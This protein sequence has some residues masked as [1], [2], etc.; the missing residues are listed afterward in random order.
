M[1]DLPA[2]RRKLRLRGIQSRLIVYFV[3]S[4]ALVMAAVELVEYFGVPGTSFRGQL[5]QDEQEATATL[6][7]IAD[8]KEDRL[9][10]WLAERQRDLTLLT[11]DQAHVVAVRD[12]MQ[13]VDRLREQH[14][15][16]ETPWSEVRKLPSYRSLQARVHEIKCNYG[17]YEHILVVDA[18]SGDVVVADDDASLGANWRRSPCFSGALK[19]D[20]EFIGDVRSRAG[21]DDPLMCFSRLVR[22]PE[23]APLCVWIVEVNLDEMVRP[24]L[25]TGRGLGERGEALLVD[26][27]GRLLTS[28]KHRLADGRPARPLEY[29]IT[30]EPARRAAAGERGTVEARDYR[31]EWVLAAYRHISI[32]PEFGWGL[33][34][35]RD[36]S[37]LYAPQR[38]TVV[39]TSTICLAGILAVT[40]LVVLVARNVT[41][42][43]RA[44]HGAAQ[45]LAQDNLTARAPVE[46]NDE[47]GELADAFNRM[48]ARLAEQQ[49]ALRRQERL[50]AL[51]QLTATVSHELRNPLGTLRTALYI[52]AQRLRGQDT[53]LDT[54]LDRM[55]RSIVRC[56]AIVSE[57]LEYN[58]LRPLDVQPTELDAWLA[59]TL[60]ELPQ[61]PAVTLHRD[62]RAAATLAID[63]ERLR[64]CLV[65]LVS[66]AG[67][68]MPRGGELTVSAHRDDGHVLIDIADTGCGILPADLPKIF[69]P[70]F[71]TKS[72]GVGLGLCIVK[73]IV[74]QHG[75]RVSV[76]SQMGTGTTFHVEL[77]LS[78]PGEQHHE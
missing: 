49:A 65:N 22:T 27:D 14:V 70:L 58:R 9:Q 25:H 1:S 32:T 45:E 47:V 43:L 17:E 57:L 33:V 63:R 24:M 59:E 39:Q 55:E 26:Q 46:S 3:G 5:S 30:A 44:L 77:P 74:E 78:P 42:P 21:R 68:A 4:F 11:N 7:L 38:W 67:D 23:K 48:V 69:E 60:D 12:L 62:L 8:L 41:R 73:Q 20:R 10:W 31:G 35:K 61:R 36:L 2:T 54:V 37:E 18:Y 52:V 6:V 29:K 50:A 64:R 53:S 15:A 34:V 13:D 56:D 19:T 28:L 51:G 40:G 75:G 66:N 72:F 71:S 16:G 76:E